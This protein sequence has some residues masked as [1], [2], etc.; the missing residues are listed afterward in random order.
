MIVMMCNVIVLSLSRAC[1]VSFAFMILFT[2]M[3]ETRS[4]FMKIAGICLFVSIMAVGIQ[5]MPAKFQDRTAS[6]KQHSIDKSFQ[7]RRR[8]WDEGFKMVKWYPIFGIGKGQWYEYHGRACHN[9]YV[10]VMAETGFTG[11]FVFLWLIL[12]SMKTF[13]KLYKDPIIQK[14]YPRLRSVNNLVTVSYVG[15]LIYIFVGNQAY[16]PWTYFYLG[17]YAALGHIRNIIIQNE[18]NGKAL[19]SK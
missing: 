18:E 14:S 10:Q 9:T 7:G 2:V 13:F 4:K 5:F 11:I 19:S 17:L 6:I 1:I 16:A 15:Y 12:L 8:S 3:L